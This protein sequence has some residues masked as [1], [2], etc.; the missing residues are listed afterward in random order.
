M[1]DSANVQGLRQLSDRDQG[2]LDSEFIC[3]YNV[4]MHLRIMTERR[5]RGI[6]LTGNTDWARTQFIGQADVRKLTYNISFVND[7][8]FLLD[9]WIL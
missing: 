9:V 8:K 4:Y 2:N 1:A 3:V 5:F 7:S 6:G